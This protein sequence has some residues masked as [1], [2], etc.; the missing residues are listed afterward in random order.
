MRV[1][2][3]TFVLFSVNQYSSRFLTKKAVVSTT[4]FKFQNFLLMKAYING[5]GAIIDLRKRGFTEDFE[6]SGDDLLWIQKKIFIRPD[7]FQITE[8][9]CFLELPKTESIIFAIVIDRYNTRGILF[10][11]LK[12]YSNKISPVIKQKLIQ[13]DAT[14]LNRRFDYVDVTFSR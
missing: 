5:A 11:H 13:M 3:R 7:D 6:L 14:H 2:M 1:I 12:N 9:Y 10:D 8:V 4:A